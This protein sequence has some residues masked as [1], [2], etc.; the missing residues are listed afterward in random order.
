MR[1]ESD[2]DL[3]GRV[4]KLVG[5]GVTTAEPYGGAVTG[6]R[7]R[8]RLA[9]GREVFAMVRPGAPEGFFAV[10]AA[11]LAWLA[12]APGGP[13]LPRALGHDRELL[14]L[15]WLA[16]GRPGDVEQLGR[17]LA[18]LHAAGAPSFGAA[19]DGWIGAAELPNGPVP[20]WLEFYALRRL[21]PYAR[22]LRD[23]GADVRDLD[24]LAARLPDLA[25]PPE[26]PSR[27]HGDLW[28]GNVVWSG[29]RGWLVDPAAHGGHRETDLAMLALF[30]EDWVPPLLDAYGEVALLAEGW[31]D[32]Q[33]LHQVHPLLVHAV[34]FGGNYLD[35][36]LAAARSYL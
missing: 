36:A 9:D 6:Q 1:Y 5:V 3:S 17:E 7:W 19:R 25:G 16:E 14:V 10:E 24:R 23:L 35:A 18:A 30:A 13:P 2:L 34:L 32:R 26:P 27:L 4:T 29:G 11:G 22:V 31:R 28:T 15:P 33:R 20:T 12:E 8:L 21:E